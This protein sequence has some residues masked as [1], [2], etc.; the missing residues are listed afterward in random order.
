MSNIDIIDLSFWGVSRF[1]R[2]CCSTGCHSLDAYI[3]GLVS[4]DGQKWVQK[5]TLQTTPT[6]DRKPYA[7]QQVWNPVEIWHLKITHRKSENLAFSDK[8][9]FSR[10]HLSYGPNGTK[11]QGLV[12]LSESTWKKLGRDVWTRRYLSCSYYYQ[13]GTLCFRFI[14]IEYSSLMEFGP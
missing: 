11:S 2:S 5:L 6:R 4:W 9:W 12:I 8:K 7:R 14:I 13:W 3:Y 1:I 10:S